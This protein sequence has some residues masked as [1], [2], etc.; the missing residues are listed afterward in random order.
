MADD[1]TAAPTSAAAAVV[2]VVLP[3]AAGWCGLKSVWRA[4]SVSN[5]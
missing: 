4:I 3:L 5:S 1:A 2:L